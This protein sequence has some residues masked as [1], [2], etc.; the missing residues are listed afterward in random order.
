M[1]LWHKASEAGVAVISVNEAYTT[2][3]VS[4]TGELL[5]DIG[6]AAVVVGRDGE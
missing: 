3:T 2:K 6:G 5:G 4:R 1:F